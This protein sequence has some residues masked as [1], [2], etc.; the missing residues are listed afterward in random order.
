MATSSFLGIKNLMQKEIFEPEEKLKSL[1]SVVKLS[2]R[3]KKKHSYIT[4]SGELVCGTLG[5]K[6]ARY[7]LTDSWC[8]KVYES[9]IT[10]NISYFRSSCVVIAYSKRFIVTVTS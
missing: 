6:L 5:K 8:S 1:V 10:L 2:G 4:L 7:L 3:S 9:V